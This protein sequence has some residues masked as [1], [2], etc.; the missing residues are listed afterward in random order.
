M[1][2]DALVRCS[3]VNQ[4]GLIREERSGY[5]YRIL[6]ACSFPPFFSLTKYLIM[7]ISSA[8]MGAHSLP[9]ASEVC[10][11]LTLT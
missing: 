1:N 3:T 8:I 10:L 6:I 5:M 2:V 4:S 7:I 11:S 9:R